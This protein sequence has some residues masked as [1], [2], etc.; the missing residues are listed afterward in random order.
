NGI[1]IGEWDGGAVAS[2]HQELTG[3]ITQ[4]DSPSSVISHATHVAGTLIASGIITSAKGMSVASTI[5]AFDFNGDSVEMN[6]E[7]INGLIL[8]NHS[9]G[10][11]AGWADGNW[12]GTYA[13]HWFGQ[14]GVRE[15]YLFGFYGSDAQTWDAI[16]FNNPYY[17]IV[18]SAGNDRNDAAPSIGTTYYRF[19]SQGEWVSA[20]MDNEGP[21]ND[22]HDNGYDTIPLK[23][24]AKNILT[25]GSINDIS[26]G[27]TNPVEVVASAFS[28]W[29]PTDDGRIK[30]D[31]VG[32]GDGLY[33]CTSGIDSYGLMSGTSMSAPN[34]TGSL[35]LLHQHYM[36]THNDNLMKSATLKGLVIHTADEAGSYLGPDYSFGWGLLN[37]NKAALLI[38]D[39]IATGYKINELHIHNEEPISAAFY[40]DGS[41][42]IAAT[43]CWTDFPGTPP[44]SIIDPPDK[45]L[46]NDLDFRVV[47][48]NSNLYFPWTLNPFS[49]ADAAVNTADNDVDNVEKIDLYNPTAGRYVIQISHKGT[50]STQDLSLIISGMEYMEPDPSYSAESITFYLLSNT[51][52]TRE[53]MVGNNNTAIFQFRSEMSGD[54]EWV[55][56][57]S[58]LNTLDG[59]NSVS[60][61]LEFDS[62]GLN[63][64]SYFSELVITDAFTGNVTVEI[65]VELVVLSNL[66]SP[67]N[68]TITISNG[69]VQL[70]WDSVQ[71][72]TL[73]NIY[74]S[75]SAETASFILYDTC[76]IANYTDESAEGSKYFYRVTA[77]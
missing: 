55:S 60:I 42:N 39:D 24:V 59:L 14:W 58:A 3:R 29:G 37:T 27:Y 73:Y 10:A 12:S 56:T 22:Y 61:N 41:E 63:P 57:D 49:P 65:P 16:A 64:G 19:N 70:S 71:G 4:V 40:C 53:I 35:A 62:N 20:V 13:P 75:E 33:S 76:D 1:V 68:L 38:S 2:G 47:D 43:I 31:L 77:E 23:T 36:N 15:D 52:S 6:S 11:L 17:L 51:T 25:V 69:D 7:A 28:G 50:I 44:Q 26:G 21:Y 74:R 8:S 34:V 54:P 45:M 72:A 48:N 5:R 66:E 30:P 46:V 18:N 67:Q 32:N 9:Y